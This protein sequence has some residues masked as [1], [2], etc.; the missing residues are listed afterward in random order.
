MQLKSKSDLPKSPDKA[1]AV[2]A[3]FRSRPDHSVTNSHLTN[4]D[5]GWMKYTADEP[6]KGDQRKVRYGDTRIGHRVIDSS[7]AKAFHISKRD[8]EPTVVATAGPG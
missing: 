4:D 2:F 1:T 3:R 7:L 6:L 8:L 5:I